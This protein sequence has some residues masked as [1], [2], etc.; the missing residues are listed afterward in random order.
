MATSN[1]LRFK[2]S[3]LIDGTIRDNICYGV[4]GE[5]TDEIEKSSGDG[6]R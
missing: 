6:I 3:P 4:E 5:S 1:W 2:D